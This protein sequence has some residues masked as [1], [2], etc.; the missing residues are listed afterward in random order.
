ML[1]IFFSPK[2]LFRFARDLRNPIEEV[3][4]GSEIALIWIAYRWKN[5]LLED[6]KKSTR[7]E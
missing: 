7:K 2:Y 5:F 3:V 1:S 4:P 6:L